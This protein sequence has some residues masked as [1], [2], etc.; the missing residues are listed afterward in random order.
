MPDDYLDQLKPE[1]RASRYTFGDVPSSGP[2]WIIATKD[3]SV[4]GFVSFG[5]SRDED[6]PDQGEVY[7]LY[8]D[9]DYWHQGV[10]RALMD[11]AQRDLLQMGGCV[12]NFV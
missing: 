3:G 1:D 10:G 9:P 2:R 5:A 12:R 11:S 4:I 7:G 6:T 8:V